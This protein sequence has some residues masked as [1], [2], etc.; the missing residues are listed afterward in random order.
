MIEHAE[1][2]GTR[3]TAE[4]TLP[5]GHHGAH[6][7]GDVPLA[8]RHVTGG[9]R[10]L[11]DAVDRISESFGWTAPTSTVTSPARRARSPTATTRSPT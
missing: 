9:L 7:D 2:D 1:A 4:C 6:D 5:A 11:A 10:D 3:F 8:A